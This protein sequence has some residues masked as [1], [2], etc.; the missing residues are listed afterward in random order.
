MCHSSINAALQACEPYRWLHG[1]QSQNLEEMV[2]YDVPDDAV[3]IKV[4]PTPLSAEVFA[5]NDLDVSDV[6]SAPQGL[7]HQI[8]KSQDLSQCMVRMCKQHFLKIR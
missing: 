4:S 8:C 6:L 2:L 5:E 3:L 1:K 7:K